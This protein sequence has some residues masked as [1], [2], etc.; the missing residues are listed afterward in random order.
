[1]ASPYVFIS[2]SRQDRQFVERLVGKLRESGIRTWTDLDDILPGQEWAREIENSVV[3]ASALIYV[4]SQNS[5]GGSSWINRE[6]NYA[7]ERRAPVVP[8]VLDDEGA[9]RMPL[10]LLRLQF[11]DFRGSFEGAFNTLV[12][13]IRRLQGSSPVEASEV[14]SK[15]YVFI[16]YADED[17]GFVVSLKDFMK[18]KGYG[19][20][21]FRESRRDF[22]ADY[23]TELERVITDAAGTLS[24]ITPDWKRSP[25]ALQELHFSRDV[26]TPVFLLKVKDPGP[27][28]AI[29]GFTFIDFTG[30][31]DKGF[32]ILGGELRRKGL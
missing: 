21:D 31:K 28:L 9:Q 32:E 26:G 15:G 3:Q 14:R 12:A 6:V 25:T 16:S 1:M 13:G 24:V 2:Y 19:Y 23:Y 10:S 11:V 4:S 8:V 7:L 27:T 18:S 5:T 29:A 30:T 20:W 17:S 22:Q